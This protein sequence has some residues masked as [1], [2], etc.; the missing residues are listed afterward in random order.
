MCPR[1]TSPEAW[2]VYLEVLP[3][4]TPGEKLQHALELS[5]MMRAFAEAGMRQLY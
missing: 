5:D 1:D 2:K 4:L 3:R